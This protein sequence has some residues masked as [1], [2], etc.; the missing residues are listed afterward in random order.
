MYQKIKKYIEI[1][2]REFRG[3][4]VFVI[5]LLLVYSSPYIYEKLMGDPL[6]ISVEIV[7]PKIA[8]IEAFDEKKDNFYDTEDAVPA[9]GELF[10]FNPNH[11]SVENWMKLGLSQKQA[12]SIKKYEA[13]G[14]QFRTLADVKKMYPITDEMYHR[15]EPYIKIPEKENDVK[16]YNNK[17]EQKGFDVKKAVNVEINSADSITLLTVRGIGPSFAS[18]IITYRKRLG[19][20]IAFDQLREVY[21]IDSTKYDQLVPQLNINKQNIKKIMINRCSIDDLRSFPYLRYK[22]ANAI[23]AYRTQHG[24]FSNAADLNKIA[25]LSPELIQKI[26]PYL[27]FND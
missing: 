11:L 16:P 5:I 4:V 8:T 6:K 10:E 26:T 3:M 27:N 18:R 1:S 15:L 12:L 7:Q 24:N 22:Q 23:I 17:F 20:F 9:K 14:G 2:P 19:G 21:G 13:K 25:I